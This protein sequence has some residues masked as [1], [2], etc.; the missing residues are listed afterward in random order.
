MLRVLAVVLTA[1]ILYIFYV[2]PYIQATDAELYE[3]VRTE[4][5]SRMGLS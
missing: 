4:Y 2:G 1:G 3:T 5:E